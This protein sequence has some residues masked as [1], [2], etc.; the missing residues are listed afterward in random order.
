MISKSSCLGL[1]NPMPNYITCGD[2]RDERCLIINV[3]MKR[4]APVKM[5]LHLIQCQELEVVHKFK[6]S[7][8]V[9]SDFHKQ[10]QSCWWIVAHGFVVSAN[11]FSWLTSHYECSCSWTWLSLRHTCHWEI[12]I[13]TKKNIHKKPYE[14]FQVSCWQISQ[15]SGKMLLRYTA[16]ICQLL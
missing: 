2:S 5:L 11:F 6:I 1:E 7:L 12:C 13:Q 10:F 16:Q 14:A 8:R 4:T 15:V 9:F 3:F